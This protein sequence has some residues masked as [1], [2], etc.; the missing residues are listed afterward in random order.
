MKP[1]KC[2]TC[3]TE[4]WNHVCAGPAARAVTKSAPRAP[5]LPAPAGDPTAV[6]KPPRKDTRKRGKR[7]RKMY[8]RDLMRERRALGLAK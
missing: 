5:R 4:E 7:K 6:A 8:Q 2:R 1:T 3:G